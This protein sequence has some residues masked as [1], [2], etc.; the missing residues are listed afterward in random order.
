MTQ[1]TIR[2]PRLR[3]LCG[4]VDVPALS[5]S[6]TQSGAFQADRFEIAIAANASADFGPALP[7]DRVCT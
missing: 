5:A 1:P 6:V 3:V 2:A 4:G 7:N